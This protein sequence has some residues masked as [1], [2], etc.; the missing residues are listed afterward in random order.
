[1]QEVTKIFTISLLNLRFHARIGV[2]EQERIIGNE[3]EV[4][5]KVSYSAAEFIPDELS[6]TISYADLYEV[7]KSEMD[8]ERLLLETA[9]TNIAQR[10]S[11]RWESVNE[12]QVNIIKIS[13]PIS[14]ITGSC[15]VEYFWKKSR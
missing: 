1:M 6:S 2:A 15:G 3:F 5:V 11:T 8:I 10:I 4:N 9:A 7:I 12:L 14:G 13:P